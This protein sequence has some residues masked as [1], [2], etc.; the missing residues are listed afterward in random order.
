MPNVPVDDGSR[1][2]RQAVLISWIEWQYIMLAI[3]A[4]PPTLALSAVRRAMFDNAT[5]EDV[6]VWLD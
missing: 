6:G 3:D 4:G 1:D 5:F 2:E